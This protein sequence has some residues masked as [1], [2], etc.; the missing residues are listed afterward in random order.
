MCTKSYVFYLEKVLYRNKKK[1]VE[2][3]FLT[4]SHRHIFIDEYKRGEEHLVVNIF[5]ESSAAGNTEGEK[6][7]ICVVIFV[8]IHY[9]ERLVKN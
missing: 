8:E 5:G 6:M 1:S 4:S 9:S 3:L 2:E 7:K